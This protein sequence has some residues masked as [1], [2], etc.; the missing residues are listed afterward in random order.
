MFAATIRAL[1][2]RRRSLSATVGRLRDHRR[3]D[4]VLSMTR[5]E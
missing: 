4:A 1:S 5:D 2:R 3:G